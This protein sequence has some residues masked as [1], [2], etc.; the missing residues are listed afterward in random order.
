MRPIRHPTHPTHA[1]HP[2]AMRQGGT[3]QIITVAPG[4]L[5][6]SGAILPLTPG[7][8]AA[9]AFP[10]FSIDPANYVS[11]AGAIVSVVRE[12]SINGGPWE[13]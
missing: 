3:P 13:T 11:S 5:N 6:P 4:G 2:I 12:I 9:A 1:T 7:A 10:A 8:A